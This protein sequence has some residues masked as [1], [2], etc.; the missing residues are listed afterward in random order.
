MAT[1]CATPREEKAPAVELGEQVVA[2]L[3]EDVSEPVT[4]S[5]RQAAVLSLHELTAY[6]NAC[7]YGLTLTNLLPYQIERIYFRFAAQ[8]RDFDELEQV[9]GG[10]YDIE[11]TQGQ[12]RELFFHVPCQRIYAVEVID[13][14]HCV[15]GELTAGTAQPGECLRHV[16]AAPS[17]YV[18]FIKR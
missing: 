12:Y 16:D 8:G 6:P 3:A 14:G 15:M 5:A 13:P 17:P 1:G 4:R 10:F 7:R 18:E 9:P 2:P 11:P